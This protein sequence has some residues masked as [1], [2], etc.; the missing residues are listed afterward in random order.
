MLERDT[1]MRENIRTFGQLTVW[2]SENLVTQPYVKNMVLNVRLLEIVAE[3]WCNEKDT[4]A[5]LPIPLLRREAL[6]LYKWF[7]YFILVY[8]DGLYVCCSEISI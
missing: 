2:A 3:Y 5:I 7:V 1:R 8:F 4:P 6:Q